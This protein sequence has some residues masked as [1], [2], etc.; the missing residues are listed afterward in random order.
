PVVALRLQSSEM[1][2]SFWNALLNE[3]LYVNLA[4]PPATPANMSL[5]RC[6]V[7]SSHSKIQIDKAVALFTKI[8]IEFGVIEPEL[9]AQFG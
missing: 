1:A 9:L 3:G 2:I 8:G 5:L 4:L 7:S 6:S